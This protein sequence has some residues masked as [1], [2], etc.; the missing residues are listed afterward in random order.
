MNEVE[1]TLL[2]YHGRLEPELTSLRLDLQQVTTRSGKRSF[3]LSLNCRL[4][5][6]QT[7][8]MEELQADARAATQ[9]LLNRLQRRLDRR[10][11]IQRLQA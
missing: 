8:E 5:D 6:G 9:R 2:F 7:V 11:N 1:Q 4:H 3:R 10:H